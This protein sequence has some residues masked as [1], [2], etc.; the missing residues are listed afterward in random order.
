MPCDDVTRLATGL[1]R[2]PDLPP[3]E[4]CGLLSR[5]TWSV[6]TPGRTLW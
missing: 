4:T 3:C 1:R 2:G 6:V 5:Q